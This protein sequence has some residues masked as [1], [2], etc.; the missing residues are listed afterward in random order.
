MNY[1]LSITNKELRMRNFK[2]MDL[3]NNK[4]TSHSELVSESFFLVINTIKIFTIFTLNKVNIFNIIV[5]L[6]K[7]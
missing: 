4:F 2:I 1:E 3:I 7:N 5:L 6:Q